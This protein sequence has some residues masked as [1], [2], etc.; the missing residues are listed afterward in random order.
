MNTHIYENSCES[1][2][3]KRLRQVMSLVQ[4]VSATIEE[5]PV[6]IQQRAN[7]DGEFSPMNCG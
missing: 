1:S 2:W 6:S 4:G 7:V 3:G 5:T